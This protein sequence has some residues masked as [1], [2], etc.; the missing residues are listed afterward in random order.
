MVRMTWCHVNQ[1]MTVHNA[2]DDL[3]DIAR[4]VMSCHLTQSM[5]VHNALDDLANIARH[6]MAW[7]AILLPK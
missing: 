1:D 5:T 7:H 3:T 4:H 2:L 6:V